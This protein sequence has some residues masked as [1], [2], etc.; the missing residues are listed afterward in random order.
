M[1][2][3]GR[4]GACIFSGLVLLGTAAFA[5]YALGTQK[6]PGTASQELAARFVSANGLSRG[7]DV[8]L[9]G[10]RVGRV[11]SVSLDPQSQ[12]AIVHF[13]L[14]ASLHIPQDSLLTIGSSTLTADSALMIEPGPG[15]TPATPGTVMTHTLEPTSLEQQIS[16]YIFGAGNLGQ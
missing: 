14:N 1:S 2:K 16:N 3:Q 5:T 13:R 4:T 11:T 10:V 8:D 12:M 15:D 7:A 9:A 6:A